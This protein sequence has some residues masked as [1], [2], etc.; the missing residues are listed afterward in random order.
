MPND[1]K[2]RGRTV[3][4]FLVDDAD[5]EVLTA[6]NDVSNRDVLLRCSCVLVIGHK[7]LGRAGEGGGGGVH[8]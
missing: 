7:L 5:E 2:F 1:K 3:T 6:L 4:A 8:R